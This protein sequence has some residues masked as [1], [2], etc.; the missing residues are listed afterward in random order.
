MKRLTVLALI[1]VMLAL[2]AL[3][4]G[5][6]VQPLIA[7]LQTPA[8]AL[9]PTPPAIKVNIGGAALEGALK[10]FCWP[11][12]SPQPAC[13]FVDEPAPPPAIPVK[14]GDALVFVI[15]PPVGA[16]IAFTAVLPDDIDAGGAAR[17]VNLLSV[18]GTFKVEGLKEGPHRIDVQASYPASAVGAQYFTEYLFLLSV[19]SSAPATAAATEPPTPA[20]TPEVT[21]VETVAATAAPTVEVTLPPTPAATLEVTPEA[22]PVETVAPTAAPTESPTPIPVITAT[23]MTLPTETPVPTETPTSVIV[24]TPTPVPTQPPAPPATATPVS[25]IAA[26]GVNVPDLLLIVGGRNFEPVAVSACT[27]NPDGSQVCVDRPLRPT[28]SRVQAAPGTV[29]QINFKG[30]RPASVSANLFNNDGITLLN[31]QAL[32]PDNLV[33]YTLP[34]ATASYVLSVE[35][36]YSGGKASYFYRLTIGS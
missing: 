21:P 32:A 5:S 23:P 8:A 13:N 12:P 27:R 20:V 26:A 22:T 33:L 25:G 9:P 35:I 15:E 2:V 24:A 6:T 19:G 30:P 16:P 29:A 28:V 3:G 34:T 36:V 1:G 18:N 10:G 11:R 7:A 14:E 31:K 17:Q 4:G